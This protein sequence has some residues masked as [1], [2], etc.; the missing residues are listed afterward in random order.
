MKHFI[1]SAVFI[2]A[3]LF[4]SKAQIARFGF[5]GGP[6]FANYHSKVAGESDNGS[7]KTGIS[8]GVLV[9]IPAGKNFTFQPAVNFVQKGT[10]DK[11]TSGGVTE[12]VK[13]T[14]NCIEVPL[15]FL[16]NT[17][18]NTGTF[19]IGAGPSFAF[20][21][22][23]K[24]KFDDGTDSFSEDVKFGNDPDNDDLKGLDVGANILA[25]YRFPNGLFFSA[26]YNAGL[27][28]LYPGSSDIGTLKSNYFAVKIG[29]M[30]NAAKSKK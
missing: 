25:G 11:E 3:T 24:W 30:L 10:Q 22:S 4:A 7:S 12:K 21:L 20:A 18:G 1:L 17:T 14:A 5:A 6:V 28:N 19:F 26:G 16:Y 27:N 8:V 29:F 13:L 15:N 23:G 2:T 9:D